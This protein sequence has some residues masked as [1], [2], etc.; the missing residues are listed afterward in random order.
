MHI[1]NNHGY[2]VIKTREIMEEKDLGIVNVQEPIYYHIGLCQI[3]TN[4]NNS[5]GK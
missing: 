1:K 4:L 2:V 5:R 3:T